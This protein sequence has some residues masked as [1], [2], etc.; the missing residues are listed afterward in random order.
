MSETALPPGGRPAGDP[1]WE[2]WLPAEAAERLAGVRVPWYVAGGCALDLFRGSQTRVHDDLEIA[3][4]AAEF[5]VIRAALADLEFDVAGAGRLWPESSPAAAVMHQTWGRDRGTEIYRL[6][7]FREPHDGD[8]WICRRDDRI[9]RPYSTLILRSRD[10]IPY[11]A[12]E[13]ALLF[14]AKYTR[15]KDLDDFAGVLPLLTEQRRAWLAGALRAVHPGHPWLA[16]MS[17]ACP[18]DADPAS[19]G[20]MSVTT[21]TMLLWKNGRTRPV[22]SPPGRR[23][24]SPSPRWAGG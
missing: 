10:G 24:P 8:S 9:R 6:D 16:V 1:R 7:V 11:L 20:A 4:P 15:P 17:G 3:V 18:A 2:P 12:P 13:V 14:K 22:A 23:S 5:P 21:A 19:Q